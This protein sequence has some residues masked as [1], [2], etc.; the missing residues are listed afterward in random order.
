MCVSF[1]EVTDLT[2]TGAT[3]VEEKSKCTSTTSRHLLQPTSLVELAYGGLQANQ[4]Q[5]V[6]ERYRQASEKADF[7][8][9]FVESVKK[10]LEGLDELLSSFN[11]VQ[12]TSISAET[13]VNSSPETSPPTEDDSETVQESPPEATDATEDDS[14]QPNSQSELVTKHS[15]WMIAYCL[16]MYVKM[17]SS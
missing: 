16:A 11:D 7:I 9:A 15:M 8:V 12:I 2:T 4:K 3:C 13:I 14:L 10:K 17:T 1:L 6:D 5:L